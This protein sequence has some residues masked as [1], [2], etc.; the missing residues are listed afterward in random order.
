MTNH[1]EIICQVL[2]EE[3]TSVAAANP[4]TDP[5]M[6]A[7]MMKGCQKFRVYIILYN[8]TTS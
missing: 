6:M 1:P 2:K 5:S 7:D 4:M 8:C 3:K